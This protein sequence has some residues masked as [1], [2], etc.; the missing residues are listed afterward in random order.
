MLVLKDN[1]AQWYDW[2]FYM[3]WLGV[4][5]CLGTMTLFLIAASCLRKERA[6]EQTQNVQYIM[7]GPE[8][9]LTNLVRLVVRGR[10]GRRRLV[11][12]QRDLV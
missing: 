11:V 12:N 1:T 10:L 8:G 3:A 7:P 2:S 6:R 4:A 9:Q 5:M